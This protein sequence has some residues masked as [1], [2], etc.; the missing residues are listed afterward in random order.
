MN[1][2]A[3][4]VYSASAGSGKTYTLVKTY[5]KI[6]LQSV[7]KN[8]FRHVLAITFTNKAVAEMKERVLETLRAFASETILEKPSQLFVDIAKELELTPSELQQRS[9][10]IFSAIL[11]N[12]A[13]FDIVTIDTFTHR[14]IRTFAYDLKLPQNFEVVLDTEQVLQEAVH[15]LILKVGK[16]E[17]LTQLLIEYALQKADDDKS[18]DISLDLNKT[19]K[20]LLNENEIQHLKLIKDKTLDDFGRLKNR[21][22]KELSDVE[23]QLKNT[24]AQL[25]QKFSDLGITK[26]CFSRGSLFNYFAKIAQSDYKA[27]KFDQAWQTNLLEGK[28]LYPKKIDSDLAAIIDAMQSQLI[29]DFTITKTLLVK[30][31]FLKNVQK[32]VVP[33]SVLNAIYNELE[34]IKEDQNV[35]LISEFNQIIA[36]E[37]KD[38]PAPFIYERLGERYQNYFIDEFQ[39]TS[40]M[41]WQNL[42]PLTENALVSEA[43]EGDQHSLML[44][45]DAKQ[46]IYRWRGGKPEQFVEL[47]EEGNPFY[48]DKEVANLETN[49]R[50]Y[51]EIITFNN[52]FFT[53]LAESFTEDSHKELYKL[54]N[55]QKVNDKKGGYV[56]LSFIEDLKNKEEE[57]ELYVSE[58]FD[59][60]QQVLANGY[61]KSEICIITRRKKDGVAVAD[62]L[63]SKGVA[64]ISSE[65]LLLSKSPE[66]KFII[67]FLYY[68]LDTENKNYKIAIL[69]F[70]F[71]KLPVQE[72]EHDFYSHFLQ[73]DAVTLFKELSLKYQIHFDYLLMHTLPFYELVE[74]IIR[75][76]SLVQDS[77]AY[78]QYFLDEVLSFS[79][80]E[81]TGIQG[82]LEYW[83]TKKEKLSIV[84][85][86]GLDAV[87]I[88]TIHKSK[89]LEFPVVIFPFADLNVYNEIEPKAW[90]P[91][92]TEKYEGFSETYIDFKKEV[93]LYDDEGKAMFDLRRSQLELDNINLL[94]V[95]LTRAQEQLYVLS[96]KKVD[97]QGNEVEGTYSGF[98]MKYLKTKGL[99]KEDVFEYDFGTNEKK[100]DSK[101]IMAMGNLLFISTSRVEHNLSVITKSGFLWD[102][103]QEM[104]IERGNLMHLILSKISFQR[105]VDL[106]F[107]ELELEGVL[108]KDKTALLKPIIQDLVINSALSEYFDENLIVYNERPILSNEGK[109]LIPDRI[110]IND[111]SV[112]IIDYKTGMFNEKYIE[113]IN[114]YAE[115]LSEMGYEID[116][117][118]L[119]FLDSEIDIKEV[120]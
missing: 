90:Y 108:D 92:A 1:K 84:A 96:K 114:S 39:D 44:V 3:F 78:V 94:Y 66:V 95:V 87:S 45:G 2:N 40:V 81:L 31:R 30:I 37:I 79:Q 53:F 57:D 99:W 10:R 25:L 72:E 107:Q 43:K 33:L 51:D 116:K 52:S 49:Y 14:I 34:L 83:E 61:K 67:N 12:Y 24:A 111:N 76:F 56:K 64:I 42:I 29:A 65:T 98:F 26:E 106:A 113:Q 71:E 105:D 82:F 36:D 85:P 60:I 4:I 9:Q 7:N 118:L 101:D 100:T 74:Q 38:Q 8:K 88:M 63:I 104:A 47:Y 35:L 27:I 55:T 70:L 115:A 62:H 46:A 22:T 89:G 17:Q 120:N 119:V 112:T 18:W 110:V 6:V 97:R 11:N 41:Q 48:I 20:L 50:S 75:S 13:A 69:Y 32:N 102:T 103:E 109:L 73:L 117:K 58:V 19:A 21:V 23:V 68:L 77:N 16:D 86:E 28:S 91:V 15:N 54:G 5:L 93:E 59:T 80:K